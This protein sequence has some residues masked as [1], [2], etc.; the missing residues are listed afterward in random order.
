MIHI[1][2][3]RCGCVILGSLFSICLSPSFPGFVCQGK[4]TCKEGHSGPTYESMQE[5][6]DKKSFRPAVNLSN[7]TITNISF[8]LYAVLGVVS[9]AE[10][11]LV[12]RAHDNAR[13]C[14]CLFWFY[15]N[16]LGNFAGRIG[17]ILRLERLICESLVR[18]S[19]SRKSCSSPQQTSLASFP[20]EAPS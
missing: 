6:F 8:T 15:C 20:L 2:A 12:N 3:P 16:Q 4:L 17:M 14:L 13:V 10:R 11:R 19:S 7:P 5:V 18:T 1:C 9:N